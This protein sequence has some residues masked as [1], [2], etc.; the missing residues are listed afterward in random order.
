MALM[1]ELFVCDFLL[2]AISMMIQCLADFAEVIMRKADMLYFDER[3]NSYLDDGWEVILSQKTKS[4]TT[5]GFCK[6]TNWL[7][8]NNS[9]KTLQ[10]PSLTSGELCHPMTLPVIIFS[11]E[12]A[13]RLEVAQRNAKAGLEIIKR[14]IGQVQSHEQRG[15]DPVAFIED[16]NQR[17]ADCHADILWKRPQRYLDIANDIHEALKLYFD[18]ISDEKREI[19]RTSHT[20]LVA[21]ITFF[22]AKL[23]SITNAAFRNEADLTLQR[24]SL[25]GIIAIDVARRQEEAKAK[26][27]EE[28]N[29][30]KMARDDEKKRVKEQDDRAKNLQTLFS[31]LGI[32][33]LPGIF[34]A[35][36]VA[37]ASTF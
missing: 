37:A 18:N 26:R 24:E 29:A 14:K 34:I 33:F 2:I 28:M 4:G 30:Q 9:L 27:S 23:K 11:Y 31:V 1:E 25:Q 22:Q 15:N 13:S 36:S 6:G 17:I 7:R 5:I 10:D 19:L 8:L 3:S 35:V 32:G 12:I 20:V 21:R 16:L